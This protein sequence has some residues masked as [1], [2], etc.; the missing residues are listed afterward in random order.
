MSHDIRII[1]AL[2]RVQDTRHTAEATIKLTPF[3]TKEYQKLIKARGETLS[4]VVNKLKP[5]L[6]LS[7]ALD[8]GCGV[9]F[10]TQMLSE[11]GLNVCGFDG[12]ADNAAEARR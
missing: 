6:N 4:Q 2:P 12:R 5:A 10:F 9:G 8:A 7:N 3:D 1:S 11:C